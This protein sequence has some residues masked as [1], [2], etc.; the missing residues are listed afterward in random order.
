[1]VHNPANVAKIM[2]AACSRSSPEALPQ[3]LETVDSSIETSVVTGDP[4][5]ITSNE[6]PHEIHA[7]L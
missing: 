5:L 6:P 7:S 4:V 2:S 1:M 3:G